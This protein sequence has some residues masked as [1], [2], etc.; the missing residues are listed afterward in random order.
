[1]CIHYCCSFQ[2]FGNILKLIKLHFLVLTA[3]PK[4]HASLLMTCQHQLIYNKKR[5]NKI[6]INEQIWRIVTTFLYFGKFSFAWIFQ[7]F[8]LVRYTSML[9]TEVLD[10]S[11]RGTAELV[12]LILFCAVGLLFF[13]WILGGTLPFLG[14]ALTFS[15]LYIWSRKNPYRQVNLYGFELKAWHL[16]FVL[17]AFG[18]LLGGSPVLDICGILIGHIY[19]YFD[20]IVPRVYGK[21]YIGCPQWLYNIFDT[22]TDVRRQNWRGGEAHRLN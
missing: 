11:P 6:Q 20:D 5:S 4:P 13:A 15:L 3:A 19:H 21:R 17:T 16:P 9:E 8:L 10:P 1:M 12:Y 22:R 7:M 18:M 2:Q 14:P